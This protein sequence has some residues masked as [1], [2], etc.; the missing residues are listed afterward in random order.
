[1]LKIAKNDL[2]LH[3]VGSYGFSRIFLQVPPS[4]FVPVGDRR[5]PKILSPLHQKFREKNPE[6]G[7]Y[8]MVFE[9]EILTFLVAVIRY[10]KI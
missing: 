6:G 10:I 2:I 9:P 1:M 4:D 3:Y 5:G 8:F 7:S